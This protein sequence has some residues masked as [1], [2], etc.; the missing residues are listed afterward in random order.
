MMTP[1]F[2]DR[3]MEM[4]MFESWCPVAGEMVTTGYIC[5]ETG[6]FVSTGEWCWETG[7]WIPNDTGSNFVEFISRPIVFVPAIGLVVVVIIVVIVVANKK[8]KPSFLD[9][10]DED[11]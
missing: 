1:G 8:R 2:P 11:E 3:G 6:M 9:G 7:A 10:D 4:G 5:E